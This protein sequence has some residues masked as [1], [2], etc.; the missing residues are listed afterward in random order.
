VASGSF[1][2]PDHEYP[3][4][5]ELRLT[6]RDSGG[7]SDTKSV[8]LDPKTVE[9]SFLSVPAG[10]QLT[11]GSASATTPFSRTVI[12]GS[13]NSVSAPSPQ[14]LAGTSYQFTSWSDGGAQSHDIVAPDAATTYTATYA[15]APPDTTPPVTTIDS[16]PSGTIKQNNASFTFSSDEANSTFE[17]KLDGGAFSA[18]SSPKKYTK[19]A[20]GQQHTFSVRATDASGNTDATPASRTWTVRL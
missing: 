12:V 20:V 17:C 18:C 16:G 7:L 13:K 9:L 5:I 3:S 6:A 2:A 11:V 1:V 4:H 15:A 14:T 19:L 10:L 8:R